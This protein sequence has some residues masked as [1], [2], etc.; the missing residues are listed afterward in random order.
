MIKVLITDAQYKHTLGAV[1]NLNKKGYYII[2]GS[3]SKNALSFFSKYCNEK[4]I[5]PDPKNVDEFTKFLIKYLENN[6]IDVLLPIGYNTTVAISKRKNELIKYT[7]IPV[8]DFNVMEIA[9]NKD[10]TMKLASKLDLITPKEYNE[11]EKI[12]RFPVVAKGIYESGNIQ[13]I[14]SQKDFLKLKLSNYIIQEYIPGEG[15]GFYALLNHGNVKAIFMHKRLREYPITGGSSTAAMNTYDEE[16]MNLGLKLLKALKWH[17]V[18]MVEFKKDSRDNQFKL[19]EINPKFWGSLDLSTTAGVDFPE[20]AIKMA[21]GEEF[22][23]VMTYDQNTKFRWLF[24]DDTIHLFANPRSFGSY[25]KDFFDKNTYGNVQ[26]D[27]IK[28]NII[29]I[30]NTFFYLLI[31]IK[32]RNLKYPHGKPEV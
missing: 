23:P 10:K 12:E 29:Q 27:D 2:A 19:M 25:M 31:H 22:D 16:L 26:F 15:Y 5:Y 4:L 30:F 18:A 20:L 7:H 9:S 3:Q 17:G 13:Y 21:L 28:P 32:N 6:H 14:N 1:R 24:P 8:A 11:K